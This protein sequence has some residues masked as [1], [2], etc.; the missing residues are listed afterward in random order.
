MIK[1]TART[2]LASAILPIS[3]MV[4]GWVFAASEFIATA[5]RPS[6]G[7]HEETRLPP[8]ARPLPLPPKRRVFCYHRIRFLNGSRA[9]REFVKAVVKKHINSLSVPIRFVFMPD[10]YRG[11]STVRIN[12]VDSGASFSRLGLCNVN[13]WGA[14]PTMTLNMLWPPEPAELERDVLHEFGHALGLQHQHQHPD[15]RLKW[16]RSELKRRHGCDDSVLQTDIYDKFPCPF[17]T[18]YD[19]DS[20]MHYQ[21]AVGDAHGLTEPINPEIRFSPGDELRI[22]LMYES[23]WYA[24]SR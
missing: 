11:P 14:E 2:V 5:R 20:V 1:T 3:I 19:P 10:S 8:P 12:F 23:G 15:C 13:P 24:N 21:V 18:A 6:H 7:T 22:R 16:N 4:V 9:E 17:S